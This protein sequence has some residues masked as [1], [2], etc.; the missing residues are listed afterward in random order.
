MVEA[1]AFVARRIIT[2]KQLSE[3]PLKEQRENSDIMF[4]FL[5]ETKGIF[6][7]C[8]IGFGLMGFIQWTSVNDTRLFELLSE[9]TKRR[10]RITFEFLW[11]RQRG[12]WFNGLSYEIYS[13]IRK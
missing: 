10:T 12:L 11:K 4:E 8:Y 13:L 3:S 9:E 6:V 2:K 5:E 1:C 7:L